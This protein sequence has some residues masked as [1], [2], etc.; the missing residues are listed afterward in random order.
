MSAFFGSDAGG[1]SNFKFS[2]LDYSLTLPSEM[3]KIRCI[4]TGNDEKVDNWQVKNPI[5]E[6]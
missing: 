2:S 5:F 1:I 4:K 6:R 3:K